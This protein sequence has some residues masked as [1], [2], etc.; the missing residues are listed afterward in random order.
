MWEPTWDTVVTIPQGGDFLA[1]TLRAHSVESAEQII[2]ESHQLVG[3]LV[4]RHPGESHDVGEQNWDVLHGVHVK[5]PKYCA[6][7]PLLL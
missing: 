5:R 3:G 2:E 4:A 1:V 7:I 6:D